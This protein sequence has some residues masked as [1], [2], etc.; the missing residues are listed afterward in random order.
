MDV[1]SG[2]IHISKQAA[3][4]TPSKFD[5]LIKKDKAILLQAWTGPDSSSKMS[6]PEFKTVGT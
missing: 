6:L 3:L 5:W 1:T 2:W 4:R